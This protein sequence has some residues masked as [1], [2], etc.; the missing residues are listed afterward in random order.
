[1]PTVP[2]PPVVQL[3][4]HGPPCLHVDGGPAQALERKDA[5]W[6]ALLALEGPLPRERPAAWLWPGA[7]PKTA[8]GS[9]RQRIFRLRQR[10]GHRLVDAGERV[11]LLPDVGLAPGGGELLA[12]FEYADCPDFAAWLL[13]QRGLHHAR[14]VDAHTAAAAAHEA[15]GELAAAIEQANALIA[16]EPLSEHAQR[17]LMKLHYLRGDRSAAIA[18]FER[19]ERLLKDELGTR[20]AAETLALLATVEAAAPAPVAVPRAVVPVALQRPPRLVGRDAELAALN[21]A[22]AAG[23]VFWLLG[24]AGMGKSRLLEAFAAAGAVP[25]CR[26]VARPGDAGVPFALLARLLRALRDDAA[27]AGVLDEPTRAQLARVVPEWGEPAP[28]AGE[29]QRLLLKRAVERVLHALPGRGMLLD[30]LHF[31]D[32][33]SLELLQAVLAAETPPPLAWGLAQR[34]GEGLPEAAALRDA[35]AELQRLHEEPL[36][37]LDEAAMAALV[38]SLGIAELDAPALAAPLVRH[39]GG[40]PLFALETLKAMLLAGP[41]G[42]SLPQPASV[43]ALIE[44][45]LRALS[46]PALAIARVAAVAGPDFGIELASAVLKRTALELADPWVELERAQVLAGSAFAHDLVGDAVQRLLPQ[47]VA[48]E[49]HASVA[50]WLAARGAEAA[51]VAGHWLAAGRWR[52]GAAAAA[53]ASS[54]ARQAGRMADALHWHERALDAWQHAGNPAAH[55][56]AAL[57]GLEIVTA[58]RGPAAALESALALSASAPGP[59]AR[60]RALSRV[61]LAQGFQARW[62]EALASAAQSLALLGGADPLPARLETERIHAMALA[63]LGRAPEAAARL[64]ALRLQV[65][66]EPDLRCRFEHRSALAY[67]L[68]LAG[69]PRATAQALREAIA[70]AEQAGDRA[71]VMSSLANLAVC[72]LSIGRTVSAA[73]TQRSALLLLE[74]TGTPDGPHAR[75][76]ELNLGLMQMQT[77]ELGEALDRLEAAPARLA[78]LGPMWQALAAVHLATLWV[79][80]GQPHRAEAVLAAAPAVDAAAVQRRRAV[81][82]ARIARWR[83]QPDAAALQEALRQLGGDPKD[84]GAMKLELSRAVDP[85]LALALVRDAGTAAAAAEFDGMVLHA[86]VRELDL[87]LGAG[88]HSA[89]ASMAATLAARDPAVLPSDGHAAEP[90]LVL[91]RAAA[92]RGDHDAARRHLH[93]AQS[94]I[95]RAAATLPPALRRGWLQL[96]PVCA[97][98]AAEQARVTRG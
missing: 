16:L 64:E 21:R 58:A 9:L 55:W 42:G 87:L 30:D 2:A 70:L 66:A 18:V 61:A 25:V 63:N 76:G 43:G 7:A 6:L 90:D 24:E 29:G 26:V 75:I 22:W 14:R 98:V 59:Q 17:R 19:F 65:D 3:V 95:D 51:R 79:A 5:G 57:D 56:Q 10:L 31:A 97:A 72:E 49:V 13:R 50:A 35:L 96:N 32:A 77:G 34:P 38:A 83:G 94:W 54:A 8:A 53:A 69:R 67:V 52:E 73:A 28:P 88:D 47:P 23:H 48:A 41:G 62:P 15:A 85:A 74:T 37:P 93:A 40:N 60:A 27:A 82:V 44:R 4:L 71:E 39:T 80:L 11:A 81:L 45:R 91:A 46:P 89:A 92:G 33:A 86:R 78:P 12:G 68:N 20:P 1:M 36:A 84:L